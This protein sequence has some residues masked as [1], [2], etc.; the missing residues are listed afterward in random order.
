M[1]ELNGIT[2]KYNKQTI[3]ENFSIKIEDGDFLCIY[4]ESGSGKTTLLN[5]LGLSLIHI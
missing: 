4:G 3:L 5:I 1:I 2:K